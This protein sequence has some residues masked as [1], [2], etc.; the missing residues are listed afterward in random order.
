MCI[1]SKIITE[2]KKCDR[3]VSWKATCPAL[4]RDMHEV[5]STWL[6]LH[7]STMHAC[8]TLHFVFLIRYAHVTIYTS[9][10]LPPA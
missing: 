4:Y 9:S 6:L 5:C 1:A 3:V 8:H 7:R 10:P 2:E